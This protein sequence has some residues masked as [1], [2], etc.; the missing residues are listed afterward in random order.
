MERGQAKTKQPPFNLD[1]DASD[2][3]DTSKHLPTIPEV[4]AGLEEDSNAPEHLPTIPE[5]SSDLE[6]DSDDSLGLTDLFKDV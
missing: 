6:D 3:S 2:E 5:V 4:S 1:R